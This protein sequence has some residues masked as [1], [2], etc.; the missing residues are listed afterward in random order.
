[1]ATIVVYHKNCMDGF[2]AA[3][4]YWYLVGKHRKEDTVYSPMQY[5]DEFPYELVN[6]YDDVVV[7]DFSLSKDATIT[8]CSRVNSV[9]IIDHHEQAMLE[10]LPLEFTNPNL[11]IVFSLLH[12]G[13]VLTW[14]YYATLKDMPVPKLL[15]LIEDRDLWNFKMPFSSAFNARAS[16]MQKDFEVWEDMLISENLDHVIETGHHIVKFKE[17]LV[18]KIAEGKYIDTLMGHTVFFCNCPLELMSDV[19]NFIAKN[20]TPTFAVLFHE[21]G[22]KVKYSLRGKGKIDLAALSKGFG[23][24]G[25]YNAAGFQLSIEDSHFQRG[26]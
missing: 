20:N 8:L 9:T 13:A 5:G 7:L 25:H 16:M 26:L 10:V 15:L 11:K 18:E 6:Q 23:G 21:M 22:G 12:S 17:A 19:G 4:A 3:F 1:M 14:R 24:G 2:G